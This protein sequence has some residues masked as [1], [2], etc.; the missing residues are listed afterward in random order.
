MTTGV[1]MEHRDPLQ[2]RLR[3]LLPIAIQMA[4]H[5]HGGTIN[6]DG[7]PYILH[8]IR[9]MMRARGYAEQIVAVL[10]DTVEDTSL[11]LARLQEAGF[12]REVVAAV[13]ALTKR[14]G[15]E[16]ASSI[17]RVAGNPLAA[18]VK[19]LDLYDNIDV[20]RLPELGEWELQRTAKYHR[21]ILRLRE[22]VPATAPAPSPRGGGGGASFL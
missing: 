2:D 3:D 20:T 11:T 9:L 10:H 12:P 4:A 13:D 6:K 16:Y 8:P 5:A 18:R 1:T 17:E 22:A 14:E 19:L 21:A 15:E 7:S